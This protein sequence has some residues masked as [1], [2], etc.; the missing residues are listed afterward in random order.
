MRATPRRPHRRREYR[1][2]T[3]HWG[4]THDTHCTTMLPCTLTHSSHLRMCRG[5]HRKSKIDV[6]CD[7]T[8]YLLEKNLKTAVKNI[9]S[10]SHFHLNTIQIQTGTH[11]AASPSHSSPFPPHTSQLAYHERMLSRLKTFWCMV[12][13]KH[14]SCPRY[15][16]C[17][18]A[19]C[20][21]GIFNGFRLC[22]IKLRFISLP[23][24]PIFHPICAYSS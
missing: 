7:S 3:H 11:L 17:S 14:T 10:S 16:L 8:N 20:Y 2:S 22:N 19:R 21:V 4:S 15:S 1:S 18:I 9:F 24:N 12:S 5:P 6:H 23:L 13:R